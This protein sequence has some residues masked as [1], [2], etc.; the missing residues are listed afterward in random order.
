MFCSTVPRDLPL[1][2]PKEKWLGRVHG[3]EKIRGPPNAIYTG[4]LVVSLCGQLKKKR[5]NGINNY[6][7]YYYFKQ[8]ILS[9]SLLNELVP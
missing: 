7:I 1:F 9:L 4:K 2:N 6:L 5:Q 8:E 3:A